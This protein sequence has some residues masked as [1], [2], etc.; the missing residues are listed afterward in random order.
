MSRQLDIEDYRQQYLLQGIATGPATEQQISVLEEQL[1][2]TLPVAYK[3]YLQVCGTQP[4]HTLIGSN[5]TLERLP[6]LQ[7]WAVDLLD[8]NN[9]SISGPYFV[10]VMHQGYTFLY[11]PLDGSSDPAVWCYLEGDLAPKKVSDCFSIWVR[12]L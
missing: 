10:F 11:F 6:D 4:P 3:A 8:E 2:K 12:M 5:C 9:V 1:G 7:E